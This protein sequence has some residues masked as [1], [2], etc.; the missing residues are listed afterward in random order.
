[1]E[2]EV[3][4]ELTQTTPVLVY[5]IKGTEIS[6][7]ITNNTPDK[8]ISIV[9]LKDDVEVRRTNELGEGEA[10]LSWYPPII[11]DL[12]KREAEG[13]N[14]ETTE[15]PGNLIETGYFT[16]EETE[17]INGLI[18]KVAPE[19]KQL[20]EEEYQDLMVVLNEDQYSVRSDPFWKTTEPYEQLLQ[21]YDDKG[22]KILPLIFQKIDQNDALMN[23]ALGDLMADIALKKHPDVLEKI[24]YED[25]HGRYT[26]DGLYILPYSAT[27]MRLA[28]GLLAV[29]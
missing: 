23:Y 26:E 4:G 24:N 5:E 25:K 21:L 20:F 10:Y 1:V 12:T 3:Q 2:A 7:K 11:V 27:T 22:D 29:I 8:P 18:E 13:Y 19:T 17:K 15:L 14:Y 6:G 16:T 9:L 28:K